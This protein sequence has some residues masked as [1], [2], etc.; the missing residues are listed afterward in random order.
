MKITFFGAVE[1]VTGSRYLVEHENVKLLVDCGMFQGP[2]E[3]AQRNLEPFPVDP[4]SIT[5][6]V[7]THAHI[8]HTGYI[9]VLVKNGFTG[10]IY[11]SQATYALCSLLLVDSGFLQEEGAKH[12]QTERN[13]DRN[14]REILYT[15]RDAE[16]ALKFFKP[17]DYNI[18]IDIGKTLKVTLVR[19]G[20]ILGSAFVIVSDGK[21]TVTFSGDLGRPQQ[22]IMKSPPGLKQTDFLVIESTYGDRL[23]VKSNTTKIT[24]TLNI[25]GEVIN[26]T[27]AKGG[28]LVIPCFSVGRTEEILYCLYQLQQKK[29]IPKIPI[30]LDSPMAIKIA[31]FFCNY[32]DEYTI[33][34][35]LCKDIFSIATYTRT[36]EESKQI[37]YIEHPVIVI[38]G[39]GMAEGGRAPFHFKHFIS[40]SKNTILFVGFQVKGTNGHSLVSG[41][42]KIKIHGELFTVKADIQ[43]IDTLSA[44]A[45]YDEIL[46]WLG[47][48]ENN[49]K[50]VFITHGE[51]QAAQS[52]KDKIEERFGWSVVIPKYL[53]SFDLD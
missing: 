25:I 37:N 51:I 7:L 26:A 11:C 27:V 16:D 18:V 29:A 31:D 12:M 1:G 6:I 32:T 21:K 47:H 41:A 43:S 2:W 35:A 48:F 34:A 42:K 40:D 30:F 8:D 10:P 39:S 22:L 33:S 46:R 3:I 53:E 52:L 45:D 36:S 19:S 49:P 4:K 28:S 13:P 24:D 5:A 9:P 20:H 17:I 38:T 44:H 50:K 14:P 15:V 23:H